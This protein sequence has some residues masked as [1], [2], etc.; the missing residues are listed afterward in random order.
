MKCLHD[1]NNFFCPMQ[2][3]FL[4]GTIK[5]NTERKCLTREDNSVVVM[6]QQITPHNIFDTVYITLC[7]VIRPTSAIFK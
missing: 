7:I 4:I 5:G 2:V 3:L 6:L 1:Y